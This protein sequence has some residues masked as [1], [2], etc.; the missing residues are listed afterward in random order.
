MNNLDEEGQKLYS[1]YINALKKWIN[2]IRPKAQRSF[3]EFLDKHNKKHD[4]YE[5]YTHKYKDNNYINS[6]NGNDCKKNYNK[7]S[8]LFHPDKF[9]KSTELFMLI[10]KFYDNNNNEILNNI[11]EMSNEILTSDDELFNNLLENLNNNICSFSNNNENITE[12]NDKNITENDV[13][14]LEAY[15]NHTP[16]QTF[17]HPNTQLLNC[18]LTDEELVDEIINSYD[19]DYKEYYLNKYENDDTIMQL[20]KKKIKNINNKLR[21][22]NEKLKDEIINLEKKLKK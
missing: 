10:K 20:Y 3:N 18:F 22:E 2:Y 7:L 16:Y 1:D 11:L 12:N 19:N 21:E 5:Y 4:K 17:K 8:I 9:T 6:N 14:N 13:D 15:L